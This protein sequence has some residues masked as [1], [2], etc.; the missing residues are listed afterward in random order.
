M[1]DKPEIPFMDVSQQEAAVI[2]LCMLPIAF[3][4]GA[5]VGAGRGIV[6]GIGAACIAGSIRLAWPLR[7]QY[8]FWCTIGAITILHLLAIALFDW[9]GAAKWGKLTDAVVIYADLALVLGA[10]YLMYR[11]VCGTPSQLIEDDPN[12][13]PRYSDRDIDL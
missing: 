8:W 6:A 10:V 1:S 2:V 7:K 12:D 13:A 4:V 3:G 9:S 5:L 11:I